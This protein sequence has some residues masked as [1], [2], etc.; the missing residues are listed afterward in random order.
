[1]EVAY[2]LIYGHLPTSA[3]LEAFRYKLT[4]HTLIHED[5]KKFFEGF[6][7]SAHPMAILSAMIAS[8]SAHYAD[9]T[10]DE[11]REMN[12]IRLLAKTPT[13]A[14]FS[15]KKSLG[16]PFTYPRNDLSYTQNFLR[17][18]FGVPT[19]DYEVAPVLD[20]GAQPAFD[21]ARRP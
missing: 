7:L 5:F 6:P 20:R 21:S 11:N 18:L 12:I 10:T 3:E 17:M 4:R 9:S 14:A 19:E 15:Y 8:L 1:M 16:Q 13:I 2:L